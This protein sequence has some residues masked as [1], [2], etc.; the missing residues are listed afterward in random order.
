SGLS[1]LSGKYDYSDSTEWSNRY[2][3]SSLTATTMVL[4]V[5]TEGATST[6]DAESFVYTKRDSLPEGIGK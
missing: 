6:A 4:K 2:V 3:V 5:Y 1:I